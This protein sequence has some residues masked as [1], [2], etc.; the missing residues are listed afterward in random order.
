[1]SNDTLFKQLIKACHLGNV[2]EADG[3]V[4]GKNY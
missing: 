4:A 2:N 1:M 3:C